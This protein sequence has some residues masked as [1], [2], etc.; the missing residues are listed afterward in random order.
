MKK[1]A[2]RG[3]VMSGAETE[4]QYSKRAQIYEMKG[5]ITKCERCHRKRVRHRFDPKLNMFYTHCDY[6]GRY[7]VGQQETTKLRRLI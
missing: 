4:L 7:I 5:N 3:F 2:Y 6:C 1:Y